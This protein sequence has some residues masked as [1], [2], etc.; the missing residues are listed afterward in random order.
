MDTYLLYA[1]QDKDEIGQLL[2]DRGYALMA[3]GSPLM[4]LAQFHRES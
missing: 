3:L 1:C 4:F 2:I